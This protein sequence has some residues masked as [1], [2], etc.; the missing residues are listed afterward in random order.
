MSAGSAQRPTSLIT[1]PY[2][3]WL[4]WLQGNSL[5]GSL[6]CFLIYQVTVWKFPSEWGGVQVLWVWQTFGAD[7]TGVHSCC[8]QVIVHV[9]GNGW[10]HGSASALKGPRLSC[11]PIQVVLSAVVS[12]DAYNIFPWLSESQE[13]FWLF[14]KL[15]RYLLNFENVGGWYAL[16]PVT[17]TIRSLMK[18][19]EKV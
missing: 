7:S 19:A 18:A 9:S 10:G 5:K 13:I 12:P 1:P 17:F 4:A 8:C 6:H 16:G 15:S 2:S 11:C 14:P 3:M